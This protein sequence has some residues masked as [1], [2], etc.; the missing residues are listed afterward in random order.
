MEPWG[1]GNNA[2]RFPG[3]AGIEVSLKAAT[4]TFASSETNMGVC[5]L[6]AR[7]EVPWNK[8]A[9]LSLAFLFC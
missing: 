1:T 3:P 5:D 6:A 8:T 9:A 4:L 7:V 2:C